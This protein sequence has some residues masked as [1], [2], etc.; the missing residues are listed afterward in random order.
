MSPVSSISSSLGFSSAVV[1]IGDLTS[2]CAISFRVLLEATKT[3]VMGETKKRKL[4]GI[5]LSGNG[6]SVDMVAYYLH[7]IKF[8]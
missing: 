3:A 7:L 6:N 2:T 8:S 4:R 5:G 1:S